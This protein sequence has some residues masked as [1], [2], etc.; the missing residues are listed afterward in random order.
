MP[1]NDF[2]SIHVSLVSS[3]LKDSFEMSYA[4]LELIQVY[5]INTCL[6]IASKRNMAT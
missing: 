6:I 5:S 3:R 4:C 1:K 2:K